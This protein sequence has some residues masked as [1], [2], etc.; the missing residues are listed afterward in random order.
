[1]SYSLAIHGGAGSHAENPEKL[2][3]FILA[4]ME[5]ILE[6][7]RAIL[8]QG[9]S[10]L[11]AV[12]HC[13][14]M[15]EDDP[16]YNAGHGAIANEDGHYELD[17]A[18]MDGK[19]LKAGTVAAVRNVK[20][21]V[22]LAT[23]IKDQTRHVMLVGGN[24]EIFARAHDIVFESDT[25]FQDAA[26]KVAQ[27]HTEEHGTV[28]AVARDKDGNLAAATSTGGWDEK[29]PGRVGDTPI[30]GA[31]TWAD[32][33]SCAI[34]C[35]GH[36]ETFIR[37]ALSKHMAVLIE[38]TGLEAAQAARRGIDY[39]VSRTNGEGGF[40]IIDKNGK[41]SSAQ[42]ST[43]LRHGWIENGGP[44]YTAMTAPIVVKAPS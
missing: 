43:I 20:N 25:Y 24:A 17:A 31:G 5:H 22:D 6:S 2:T 3:P 1:M 7:G 37:T 18:I 27:L 23:L 30:I 15:L 40:I 8:E 32:N 33:L 28:G 34:S 14:R 42:S 4:S 29:I 10:A 11:E 13:V 35:T 16:L 26:R 21:P 36:G 19:T 44:V 38:E 39:L 9:G 41:V 12:R